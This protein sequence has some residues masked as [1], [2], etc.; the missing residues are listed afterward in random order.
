MKII[1]LLKQVPGTS[2]VDI[3][4]V[5]GTLKRTGIDSKMNP[6][7]LYALETALRIKEEHGGAITGLSMGPGQASEILKEAFSMGADAGALLSDK[8][9]AGSDVLA[10]A[11]AL[12]EAV[13]KLGDF[14][15]IICGKQTTDGDTAQV[16][17][18][19]AEFLEIPHVSNVTEIVNVSENSVTLKADLGDSIQT[20]EMSF[21][22]LIA[23]EKIY[24]PRLPSFKKKLDS[25]DRK[26]NVLA[27]KDLC[28]ADPRD[29]GLDGSPTQVERIFPPEASGEK[30]N[31][32]GN[33]EEIADFLYQKLKDLKFV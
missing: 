24:T 31:I 22:G 6:Y 32:D 4:E 16:G 9:F 29:Y 19:T 21:P 10:T 3:D 30:I 18:E 13:K 20:L 27:L 8:A 14:D 7:D 1:V 2:K 15:L 28:A 17:P 26:I 5:T 12:S 23:V 33:G 11:R 25:A